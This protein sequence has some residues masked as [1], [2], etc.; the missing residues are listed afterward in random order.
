M[1]TRVCV[2]YFADDCTLMNQLSNRYSVYKEFKSNKGIPLVC[3]K[4]RSPMQ[5]ESL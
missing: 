3:R 1:K 4:K 2:K 5:R